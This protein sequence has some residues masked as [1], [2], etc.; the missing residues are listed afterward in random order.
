MPELRKSPGMR[1][2][3]PG[4]WELTVEAGRDAVTG[5]RRRVSRNFHGNLREAKKARASLLA[6]VSKG[7]HLGTRATVDELFHEWI[8]ELERKGR[9]ANTVRNYQKAY[10]VSIAPSLGPIP[11]SNVTTKML[12]DL[13]G[14]HQDRG[15]KP[16]SVRQIHATI[17]SMMTQACRWGWRDSN[18]AQWAEPPPIRVRSPEVPTPS[19]AALLIDAAAKSRRPE[20]A[21]LI[22]VALTT[23]MRRGELCALRFDDIDL[24]RELIVVARSLVDLSHR[25]IE[26][27]PTKNRRLRRLA[28]DPATLGAIEKQRQL[29]EERAAATSTHPVDNAFVFSDAADGSEPWRPM[30]VTRYFGRLARRHGLERLSFHSLRRFIDTYGPD[31]G[32][33]PVQVAMRVGHDPAVAARFYTGSVA[34]AD[35]RLASAIA[36]LLPAH[37]PLVDG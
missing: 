10:R 13:Y 5:K 8:R 1:E 22:L 4:I 7:R 33:A 31:L 24:D 12:T 15:L 26:E 35:R 27:G 32:F 19:E 30:M 16:A 34:D 17:S 2:R 11:V 14:A 21:N 9:S 25:P 36:S 6:E 29:V 3:A 20:Y 37:G 18:P 28:V 23:G